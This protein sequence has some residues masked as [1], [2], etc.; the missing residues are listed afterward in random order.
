MRQA[1]LVIID[2]ASCSRRPEL[3]QSPRIGCPVAEM[4]ACAMSCILFRGFHEI[5]F[6]CDKAVFYPYIIRISIRAIIRAYPV[7]ADV[8]GKA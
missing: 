5:R 4:A 7:G 3:C 6:L 8:V 1:A 2:T